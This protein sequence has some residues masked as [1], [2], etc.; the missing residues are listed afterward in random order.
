MGNFKD[1]IGR[2]LVENHTPSILQMYG[3]PEAKM[4]LAIQA[5]WLQDQ[6]YDNDTILAAM[7]GNG[8]LLDDAFFE[9]LMKGCGVE[10]YTVSEAKLQ[11]YHAGQKRA[12]V[13]WNL[14]GPLVDNPNYEGSKIRYN[15]RFWIDAKGRQFIATHDLTPNSMGWHQGEEVARGGMA[16]CVAAMPEKFLNR[17][18]VIEVA[19]AVYTK[20]NTPSGRKPPERRI[21]WRSRAESPD[22]YHDGY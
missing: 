21:R 1:Y 13:F 22:N 15:H 3:G 9:S 7:R 19:L 5:D 6:G 12:R 20:A 17:D 10:P 2:R 16:A 4:P 14:L 18:G 8:G 11:G